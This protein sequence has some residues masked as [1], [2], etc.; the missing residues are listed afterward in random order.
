[1][2][3]GGGKP[4]KGM[5]TCSKQEK[6]SHRDKIRKSNDEDETN[7]DETTALMTAVV[8]TRDENPA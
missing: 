5:S 2:E 8:V 4:E 3:A 1:M 6:S 7:N